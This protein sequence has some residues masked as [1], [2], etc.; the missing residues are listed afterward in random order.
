M[1]HTSL[2]FASAP[3]LHCEK[4]DRST[5][6]PVESWL[7]SSCCEG[8]PPVDP[9]SELP[10]PRML[11]PPKMS[12]STSRRRPPMPPP[13][14]MPPG[15]PP[16][17]PPLPPLCTWEVSSCALS[18]KLICRSSGSGPGSSPDPVEITLVRGDQVHVWCRD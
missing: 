11:P 4:E 12:A 18:L 8:R 1:R 10:P 9:P 3:V 14:W 17:P 13:T 15:N 6:P 16:P 2:R 5:S 7:L